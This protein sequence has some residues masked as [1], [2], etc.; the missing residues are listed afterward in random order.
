MAFEECPHCYVNVS[1]KDDGIC[2]SCGKHKDEKPAKSKDDAIRENDLFDAG[3]NKKVSIS[4]IVTGLII[5]II[6]VILLVVLPV[7]P[8]KLI[9][10]GVVFGLGLLIKGIVDFINISKQ[11]KELSKS[12]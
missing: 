6:T 5:S 2:S 4:E 8:R 12:K 3:H 11:I 7:V 1:F 10:I 9:S